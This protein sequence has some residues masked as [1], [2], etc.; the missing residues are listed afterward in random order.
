LYCLQDRKK[1]VKQI[2]EFF[3]NKVAPQELVDE[4][5]VARHVL[6]Y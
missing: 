6:E 5:K 4:I 3:N 1:T 2:E